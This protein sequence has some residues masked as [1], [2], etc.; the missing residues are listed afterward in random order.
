MTES[1]VLTGS[2]P[3]SARS[4][5]RQSLVRPRSGYKKVSNSSNVDELLFGGSQHSGNHH[6]FGTYH[7]F[8]P[9]P[10]QSDVDWAKRLPSP[11][12]DPPLLWAPSSSAEGNRP[13]IKQALT[14][15]DLS[16]NKNKYRLLKH[17]PTFCDE[18]LFGPKLE[19]PDF[20]APWGDNKKTP[21]PFLFSS[22]DYKMVPHDQ[23]PEPYSVDGRPPSR[24]GSRPNST[25]S[26]P[27]SSSSIKSVWRP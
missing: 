17:K 11:K 19:E 2:R 10:A 6:S 27:H 20:E 14:A 9:S 8:T 4:G 16:S 3:P 12:K 5:S 21:T 1:L 7:K 24:R 25:S 13:K 23:N 26:R 18:T 22:M 15:I